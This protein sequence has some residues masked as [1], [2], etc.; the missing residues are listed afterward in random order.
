MAKHTSR[1]RMRAAAIAYLLFLHQHQQHPRAHAGTT[2]EHV[3]CS[4]AFLSIAHSPLVFVFSRAAT[5]TAAVNYGIRTSSG[6]IATATQ[7]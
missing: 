5:A 6:I 3:S 1:A 4:Q 2:H 7:Q